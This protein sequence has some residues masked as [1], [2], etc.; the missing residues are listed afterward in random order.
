MF[1]RYD[2]K[3]PLGH[4]SAMSD[5]SR[6]I[7]FYNLSLKNQIRPTIN[8]ETGVEIHAE[9]CRRKWGLGLTR[10]GIYSHPRN[11]IRIITI[12]HNPIIATK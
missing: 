1:G 10:C 3:G 11:T 7:G 2:E 8:G 4:T 12:G 5:E 9:L 6:K